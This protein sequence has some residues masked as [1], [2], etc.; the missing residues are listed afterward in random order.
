GVFVTPGYS[1][2]LALF[3][4]ERQYSVIGA[5]SGYP[6]TFGLTPGTVKSKSNYFPMP[7]AGVN[8]RP[9]DRS[10]VTVNFTAHGGM[11]TDYR[12]AT[13]YGSSHTGVDLAQ[14]FLTTTYAR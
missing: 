9:N 8:F 6:G 3:N 12:T 11:N 4:P 5:P 7:A 1:L 13:F 14:I 10:A 2:S